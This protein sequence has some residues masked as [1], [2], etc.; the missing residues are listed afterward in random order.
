VPEGDTIHRTANRLRPVLVGQP[1]VRIDVPR[2]AGHRPP[3]GTVIDGVDAVGKHLVIHFADRTTLR[4]HM[5]MTG[6]WHLYKAGERWRKPAHLA[7]AVVE[8]EGWV[9]VCFAAPVVALENDVRSAVN[10]SHLSHL[11]PDLTSPDITDD[12]L[13]AGVRHMSD[14]RQIG[15]VLLDQRVVCG[16]GNIFKNETLFACRVDPFTPASSLDDRTKHALLTTASKLLRAS[17]AD[18]RMIHAVYGKGGRPCPRCGTAIRSKQQ[19]EQP[20]TTYWCPQCQK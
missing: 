10:V 20:R 1:L 3:P 4:T 12:D 17:V 14:A 6:S 18:G 13:D 5:R 9:A 16:I 2:A 15:V 11:G 8:V 19:G 7:R